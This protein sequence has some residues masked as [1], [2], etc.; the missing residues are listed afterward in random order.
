MIKI[1]F[2]NIDNAK[3]VGRLLPFWARGRR[4]SLF[5]QACLSPLISIHNAFKAWGIERFIE[6]SVTAQKPSIE[7]YLNYKLKKYFK[8]KTDSFRIISGINTAISCYST[9]GWRNDIHWDNSLYWGI[10]IPVDDEYLET[11]GQTNVYAPAIIESI[12]YSKEDYERDIRYIMSKYMVTFCK[13]KII[14]SDK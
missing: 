12:N 3:L 2:L 7:W 4:V 13:I 1:N 8:T 6:G 11:R 14:I 10:I 5:L 9:P